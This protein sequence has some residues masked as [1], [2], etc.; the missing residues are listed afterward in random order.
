MLQVA[1]SMYCWGGLEGLEEEVEEQKSRNYRQCTQWFGDSHVCNR[2]RLLIDQSLK[3][4]DACEGAVIAIGILLLSPRRS[5]YSFLV[6]NCCHIR[7]IIPWGNV[8]YGTVRYGWTLGRVWQII[9]EIITGLE[10]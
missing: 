5:S 8:R 2:L 10:Y 1:W 9:G 7:S 3:E 6:L 4:I